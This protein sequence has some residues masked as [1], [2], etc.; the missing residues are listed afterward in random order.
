MSAVIEK[1]NTELDRKVELMK[2]FA[3][4]EYYNG[5]LG[6][7]LGI[8]LLGM[9][10]DRSHE[11]ILLSGRRPTERRFKID[12]DSETISDEDGKVVLGLNIQ[13]YNSLVKCM[14]E[15]IGVL[16]SQAAK[17]DAEYR[18]T[19]QVYELRRPGVA[20][21]YIRSLCYA[22]DRYVY[23]FANAGGYTV[24]LYY[25]DEQ[26]LLSLDFTLAVSSTKSITIKVSTATGSP[27][28]TFTVPSSATIEDAGDIDKFLRSCRRTSIKRPIV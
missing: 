17:V 18:D 12:L 11:W 7:K 14:F 24:T 8:A 4:S 13:N 25:P 22:K 10:G 15:T 16:T 26:Q 27:V 5:Y 21:V 1:V 3:S 23:C 6:P 2:E 19:K 20:L 28:C 9:T